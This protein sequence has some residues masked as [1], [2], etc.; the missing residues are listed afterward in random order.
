MRDVGYD[1]LDVKQIQ[2]LDDLTK[3]KSGVKDLEVKF[4]NVITFAYDGISALT[5]KLALLE[6]F[7]QMAETEVVKR[8]LSKKISDF[9]LHFMEEIN[10]T[11]KNF[12]HVRRCPPNDPAL[13]QFAGAA[14]LTFPA[15]NT[16]FNGQ[17]LCARLAKELM[18]RLEETWSAIEDTKHALLDIPESS[19]AHQAYL[20]AHQSI[21]QFIADTHQKWFKSIDHSIVKGPAVPSRP[22]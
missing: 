6:A 2:W 4:N 18:W 20:S 8:A 5:E 10:I 7:V 9:Y 22:L 13:P 1:V 17:F 11:K 16:K 12:D 19:E 3:F 15:V 14:R 21:E